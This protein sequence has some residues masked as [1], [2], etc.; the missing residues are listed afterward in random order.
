LDADLLI[1]ELAPTDMILQRLGR[2]WRHNRIG[3]PVGEPEVIILKEE[4]IIHKDMDRDTAFKALGKKAYVYFP[5]ILLRT[6]KVLDGRDR[7]LIPND[8]RTLIEE[9]YKEINER[10]GYLELKDEMVN[11]DWGK[12]IA[13]RM[14]TNKDGRNHNKD[15]EVHAVTRLSEQNVAIVMCDDIDN[16]T[17]TFDGVPYQLDNGDKKHMGLAKAIHKNSVYVALYKFESDA[18]AD[19]KHLKEYIFGNFAVA[20][21]VDGRLKFVMGKSKLEMSYNDKSGLSE[22]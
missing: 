22:M 4:E 9:T 17:I 7:I 5:Y 15:D 13:Q 2:L 11:V 19:N 1:T 20:K 6:L 8:M 14:S 10:G 12:K 18:L 3:R 21:V 16:T